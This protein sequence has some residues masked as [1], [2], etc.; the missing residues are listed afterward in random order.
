MALAGSS[1]LTAFAIERGNADLIIFLLVLAGVLAWL[2]GLL[3]RLA[4]Y[5]VFIFAAMLKYYP[6]TLMLSSVR[7]S[8]RIFALVFVGTIVA[9]LTFYWHFG[10]ELRMAVGNIGGASVFTDQFGAENLPLGLGAL[11]LQLAPK[12][13]LHGDGTL[14]LVL[15]ALVAASVILLLAA[16]SRGVI[17]LVRRQGLI[18]RIRRAARTP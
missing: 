13:G 11:W 5:S 2:G 16:A 10:P 6:I 15:G 18:S 12:L 14:N 4:A 3:P 7:E 1:S 8:I 17:A 9:L